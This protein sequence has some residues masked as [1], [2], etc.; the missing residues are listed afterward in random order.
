ML[1]RTKPSLLFMCAALLIVLSRWG[2]ASKP[3]DAANEIVDRPDARVAIDFWQ[4]RIAT[5][6]SAYMEYTLL[7]EA[8]TRQARETGD[9]NQYQRAETALR[10]A[11]EIN[12]SY[13][14][15]SANLAGV[16]LALHD[17]E[18]AMTIAEPLINH[19]QAVQALAT[20]GDAYMA[21][22][23][24]E[25]AETIYHQLAER[26]GGAAALSRL[27]LLEQVYGRLDMATRRMEQAI[28]ASRQ[29][30]GYPEEIAW[31]EFQLG[32]LYFQ[33]GQIS[34]AAQQYQTA[35]QIF[36]DYYLAL[37]G[38]GKVTAAQGDYAMAIDHYLAATATVPHP[39]FL[40]ILGDLYFL[41]GEPEKATQ[42]YDTVRYIGQ[43]NALNEQVYDRQLASF[44]ANHGLDL[45]KAQLL[46]QKS[47]ETRQDYQGYDTAAWIYYKQGL[48]NEAQQMI[49]QALQFGTQ[50][51]SLYYHAG[52]IAKAQGNADE[53]KD[54][55][56]KALTLN[57]Y[58][59]PLQAPIAQATLESLQ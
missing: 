23:D 54:F 32:E 21:F 50:D 17:F 33:Q 3:L 48:F 20:M 4:K 59:D 37:A 15:A 29:G 2:L 38:L 35:L 49:E 58:F 7:A 11:L 53:A 47:L 56:T 19:P 25:A 9:V 18:G 10:Q 51:A 13:I 30:A 27:A 1:D 12:P 42:Q 31:Y 14:K 36:P 57:P 39:D 26:D 46:A 16:L 43:L 22:G 24:Y 5:N 34:A 8:Y 41:N 6:P 55:L 52:L 44:Y 40:A 45:T 28:E